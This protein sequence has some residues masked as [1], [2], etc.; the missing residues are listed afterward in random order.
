MHLIPNQSSTFQ[1]EMSRQELEFIREMCQN[2]LEDEPPAHKATRLKLFV[3]ASRI[4]GWNI[5]D[6]GSIN[7]SNDLIQ[8]HKSGATIHEYIR[9]NW[10]QQA[11]PDWFED[12]Q[13]RIKTSTKI[14]Y[15]WMF[16]S[17]NRSRWLVDGQLLSD[18]E[19]KLYYEVETVKYR[20][21]GRSWEVEV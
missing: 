15:E 3:G 18:D 13:Y 9:G 12:T 19:A 4:L 20:K 8:A 1:V 7:R 11:N 17:Q 2:P 6:D 14:V 5:N 21:T 10:V 16:Y